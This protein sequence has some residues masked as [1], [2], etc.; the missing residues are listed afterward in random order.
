QDCTLAM[1]LLA[2]LSALLHRHTGRTDVAIGAAV[3]NRHH[4]ASEPLIGTLVNTVV[5][6]TDLRDDPAFTLLLKRVREVTLEAFAHQDIPFEHIV[7]EL[8]ISRDA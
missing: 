8:Q 2:A 4:A 1:V 5:L 6:R 7:K 3:A